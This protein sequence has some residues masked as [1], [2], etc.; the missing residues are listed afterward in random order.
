VFVCLRVFYVHTDGVE[1]SKI[2]CERGDLVQLT[3]F[4]PILTVCF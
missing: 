1:I 4:A 2:M 3:V